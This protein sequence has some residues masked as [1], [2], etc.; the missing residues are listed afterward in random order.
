MQLFECE[1]KY[2]EEIR[3]LVAKNHTMGHDALP[4]PVPARMGP[5]RR[6]E[7]PDERMPHY[8]SNL[9]Y[10]QYGAVP[11]EGNIKNRAHALIFCFTI[12][13][14]KSTAKCFSNFSFTSSIS[15]PFRPSSTLSE[16]TVLPLIPQ[17]TIRSK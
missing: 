10:K 14:S 1:S 7:C 3:E 11:K 8:F 2:R 6:D 5:G 16:V 9:F 12:C 17:G 4:V 15:I 13:A